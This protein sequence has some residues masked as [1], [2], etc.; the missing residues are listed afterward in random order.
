MIDLI[1]D[2]MSKHNETEIIEYAYSKAQEI[3]RVFKQTSDGKMN[4]EYLWAVTS[5]VMEL[6]DIL[7]K[8]NQSNQL[9]IAQ[10]KMQ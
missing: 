6:R 9:R 3:A 5:D 1:D 7:K 2:M 8:M 4:A 10:S